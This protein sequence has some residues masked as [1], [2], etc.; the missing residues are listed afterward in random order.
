MSDVEDRRHWDD[1][2][3]QDVNGAWLNLPTYLFSAHERDIVP[4]QYG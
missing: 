4:T 2:E 3:G 1:G